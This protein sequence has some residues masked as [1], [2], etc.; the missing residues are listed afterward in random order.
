M[1]YKH[2]R[3]RGILLFMILITLLIGSSFSFFNSTMVYA[4][5]KTP[6][7]LLD[8]HPNGAVVSSIEMQD[9]L[10]I[11]GTAPFDTAQ[12][13]GNDI[14]SA[15]N[16]VRTFDKVVYNV[17]ST[18]S[19]NGENPDTANVLSYTGGILH[20][21]CVVPNTAQ[22]ND[23]K[24]RWD[25]E[26]LGLNAQNVVLSTDGLTLDFDYIF[27]K[28]TTTIPGNR[29]LPI[30]LSISKA[31]NGTQITPTFTTYLTG[32]TQAQA[33]SVTDT[34]VVVS[35]SP[36]YNVQLI[37]NTS[38]SK[39][40]SLPVNGKTVD[41]RMYGYGISIQ[42]DNRGSA[43]NKGL[44][45]LEVPNGEITFDLDY[46]VQKE[47]VPGSGILT[48]VTAA[49]S[50]I[51]WNYK[52]NDRLSTG[53]IPN[54]TMMFGVNTQ[55]ALGGTPYGKGGDAAACYDS[56]QITAQE[57]QAEHKITFNVNNYQF[58]PQNIFPYA[59]AGES[60]V[61]TTGSIPTNLGVFIAGYVELLMPLPSDQSETANYYLTVNDDNFKAT[62]QSGAVV[63]QQV[64][65]TDDLA[66]LNHVIRIPGGYSLG[67][68]Y[69]SKS[70]VQLASYLWV[71]GDAWAVK[72][73]I[74][75]GDSY[76]T[77]A[78]GDP[79]WDAYSANLLAKFD[80][81]G[82]EP[83]SVNG[84]SY[85]ISHETIGINYGSTMTYKMLYCAL[86]EGNAHADTD[87]GWLSDNDMEQAVEDDFDYFGTLA[88][89]KA[90]GR[91][92]TGVFFESTGGV[93][94]GGS[95][96]HM[97]Y[98]LQVKNSAVVGNV[99]QTTNNVR[100]WYAPLD[101]TTQTRLIPSATYPT[102]EIKIEK[103]SYIKSEYV[104]GQVK[105]GTHSPDW[106]CGNSLLVMGG[107]LSVGN[108]VDQ[109]SGTS[110]KTNY[111]LS[112]NAYNVLYSLTPIA[113][114]G[115]TYNPD[116]E[117]LIDV[118]VTD[119][120]P[121]GLKYKIGSAVLGGTYIAEANNGTGGV[122]N[123][124]SRAPDEITQNADGS[125]TLKWLF[126]NV[127]IDK[128]METI[129]FTA[130]IAQNTPNGTSFETKS[131]ISSTGDFDERTESLKTTSCG[132]TVSVP[133]ASRLYKNV[134]KSEA[135]INEIFTYAMNYRNMSTQPVGNVKLFD[136]LP[137][138]GDSRGTDF[139][140]SYK[141]N[142]ISTSVDGDSA[143]S[144][145]EVY[146]TKDTQV[147][148]KTIDTVKLTENGW[149]KVTGNTINDTATAVLVV[150]QIGGFTDLNVVLGIT[151]SGNLPG[152]L[153][154]GDAT[155]NALGWEAPIQAVPVKVAVVGR[156][157]SG[158]IWLDL[159]RNGAY[160]TGEHLMKDTNIRLVDNQGKEVTDIYGNTVNPIK[161]TVTGAYLFSNL[162][163]GTYQVIFDADAVK[164]GTTG[165]Q[166]SG[167]AIDKDN[168]A[169]V[170]II[171]TQN[172]IAVE[173]IT[174][175][176]AETLPEYN[177]EL[178]NQDCGLIWNKLEGDLTITK[179]I[180]ASSINFKQ[181][182]PTFIYKVT[183]D[184]GETY[185]TS[186]EFTAEDI[187]DPD[188]FGNVTKS[189][190][191]SE[192][193]D[194][195]YSVTEEKSMRYALSSMVGTNG[196]YDNGTKQVRVYYGTDGVNDFLSNSIKATNSKTVDE[197]LSST[198][199]IINDVNSK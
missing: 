157:V 72:G 20:V 86:K 178:K 52:I 81:E 196:K 63:T 41:G 88:E 77:C 91:I 92:C 132:I 175:A 51:L 150:G 182:N 2:I 142:T 130:I 108:S 61:G 180:K 121:K 15:D 53:V 11:T 8:D 189:V 138:N 199:I 99:Y 22:T 185:Y 144:N 98:Y 30:P 198:D 71:S 68:W 119:K 151:P 18:F 10:R 37:R 14:S 172:T 171:N 120:L 102:P 188:I 135:E 79:E 4:A 131:V 170:K 127:P 103:R 186:I 44:K 67:S 93:M 147:R 104:D 110:P 192:K 146:Y 141:L 32:N 137:Y 39:K 40:A 87:G 33:K 117:N 143:N 111:D 153:Y 179:S 136:V 82:V 115:N 69:Y 167:V 161:T 168:N 25:I 156:A 163:A 123:G 35:A 159:N 195:W 183:G 187:G 162:K 50:P 149:I 118:T 60:Y 145:I 191:K 85:M 54:R 66:R 70:G 13:V 101:R 112:Q 125:T 160:D 65:T 17:K 48:D 59:V 75:R 140:G 129:H 97:E 122:S 100:G 95:R 43:I 26:S 7:G 154:Q 197:Y 89:L 96:E 80:D 133:L 194:G 38:I 134:D 31:S 193:Y 190:T 42:L 6:G 128:A 90:Q 126:K 181:G 174:M 73:S 24:V 184:N 5:T 148:N 58:S 34:P 3:P 113:S 152:D 158:K 107:K 27:E 28:N 36:N 49:M 47:A 9:D 106:T 139:N 173:N 164:Y 114:T 124:T 19:I 23:G 155:I 78:N 74:V 64:K 169:V 176:T 166:N 62:S 165:Y 116:A 12:G 83:T 84:K 1:I 94:R 46:L 56:G 177:Y 57:K 16:I 76:F 29:T 109:K 105:A 21:K 55:Y 45:G